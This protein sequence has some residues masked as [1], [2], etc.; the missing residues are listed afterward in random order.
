MVY[1]GVKQ[2]DFRFQISD[3]R[4]QIFSAGAADCRLQIA[5]CRLRDGVGQG[6]LAWKLLEG[7]MGYRNPELKSRSQGKMQNADGLSCAEE[8]AQI[9][10]CRLL[11]VRMLLSER[12]RS[13]CIFQISDCE[14]EI[15]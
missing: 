14:I 10:D 8:R 2:A 4:L 5:D 11:P 12:T 15:G 9:A 3:F 13:D 7:W 1:D 6:N